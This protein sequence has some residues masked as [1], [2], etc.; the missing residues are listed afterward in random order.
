M[1]DPGPL[2]ALHGPLF[3]S[4]AMRTLVSDRARLQRM[5]DVEAALAR[6]EEALGIIPKGTA[7]FIAEVC[8][9]DVLD[10]T[11]IGEKA[12]GSGNLAIP[13][14]N[15]L[16]AKLR[17]THPEAADA[18][19]WGATSQDVIDTG[20]VMELRD[21]IGLLIVDIERARTGFGKL[22][23]VH[24]S[25]PMAG[26]TW[27]QQA[28]PIPFGLKLAG[29]AAA[30]HRA[31]ERLKRVCDEGLVL[32]F[33]GAAGTLASLDDK[34]FAIAEKLAAELDLPLPDAPWHSHRDRLADAASAIAILTGTCGK[35]ARD[36]TLLMQSEVAE[37]FEPAAEGRGGSSTMP[38]KRNPVLASA[39]LAAATAAPHLTATILSA[40]VQD[41]E[42]AAGAW[43]AE[44]IAFPQLLLLASGAIAAIADIAEGLDV[45][46][47][48]M[49]ANLDAS[50]GAVMAEAVSFALAPKVGK[51][52][53]HRLVAEATKRAISTKT[54]LQDVLQA[55]ARVTKALSADKLARLFDPMAYLG[56]AQIFIDRLLSWSERESS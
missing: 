6:A 34:G 2:S 9:A 29:Y 28:V 46:T 52:E 56:A 49:R 17:P 18:V 48:R 33:G 31:R 24:R 7:A 32:Q 47:K 12:A 21:G 30:L 39:A 41:H 44:W 19:H 55:D 11:A 45:D 4:A 42:R 50:G 43:P 40:Q 13:L 26:R 22:A 35:I 15:A 54:G 23:G 53:A 16:R 5:L 51:A 20:L 10:L 38:Q 27:L 8:R 37:A 1:S 14:V 36:V 3:S 25:T